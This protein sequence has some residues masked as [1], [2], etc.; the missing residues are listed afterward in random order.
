MGR[1]IIKICG[2]TTAENTL[3]VART[4]VNMIGFVCH[5]ASMRY[6][7]PQQIKSLIPI[8]HA[9][10]VK[11][12]LVVVDQVPEEV[13][14][15]INF[16]RP[17]YIQLHGDKAQSAYSHLINQRCIVP[18]DIRLSAQD[19]RQGDVI[20]YDAP[21]PGAGDPGHFKSL[22]VSHSRDYFIA[23]GITPYNSAMLVEQFRPSGIDVSTGVEEQPGIKSIPKIISLINALEKKHV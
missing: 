13:N 17:D 9:E 7:S 4:G 5:P 14:A 16:L 22:E 11:S 23:G 8:C 21:I 3:A 12:V 6:V 20:L 10:N 18:M 1:P 2:C 19:V 15:L